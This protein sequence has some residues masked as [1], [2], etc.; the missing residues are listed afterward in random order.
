[1]RP[2]VSTT[3]SP[4]PAPVPPLPLLTLPGLPSPGVRPSAST[5]S[6]PYPAPVPPLP[7]LT[8]PGLPCT[9]CTPEC[10][11]YLLPLPRACSATTSLLTLP[12]LPRQVYARVYQL[13]PPPTP[14]LFRHYL[15]SPSP[16]SPRQVCAR[17]HQLPPPPTPRLFR[18]YL[19]P[20]SPVSPRQVCARVHQLPPP[21]TPRLFR[22][23]LYSP[24]PVSPEPGVRPSAS[25]TSSPYPAPVPPLP[26][27]TLPG[28]PCTRYTPECINYLLPLPR[29]CSA[30]TSLLT[31]PVSL[32]QVCA[33]VYQLPPP[34][35]P[36]LFHHYLSTHPPGLPEP[37]VRPSASTTS[38][39]YP[40]PVPPLPLPTLP[41]LPSPG[42]R[43]SASTTS[44]PYPAPVPPLPLYSPS[45]V[46]LAR[47]APECINYLLPL[48][49]A[50]SATTSL[51]TLPG[52]PSPGVRPSVS[53]TSSPYPAPVP[54]LPLYSPSPVSPRQVCA[55]VYQL[56]P[57]PTPRLFHHYLS[58]HPP[59]LPEPGVRPSASTTSSPYPAP[60]PPLPLPTLPGLPSPGV[61]P[62]ASTT[63]SPYPA[64]VPPLPLYSPSPVS[65]AR[66]APECINYLLPLPRAC[67]ATTSLLT[68][69]GLPSPGVR[70][71]VSTTS[72]P[73]PAPVPPLP[74]YSPSPVSP[75]QVCARVYQLP[76]PPTPRLFHHYLSTHPP[77]LPEPGVRPSASTT[78]SPY[79]APVPPLPLYSPS[80]VSP[81]QVCAGV[82][83]LPPPPT[84]R[85]FR[86][87]L[88]SHPPRS[89][90]PGVR[91]SVSTTS[92]PYPAPVPPLP[93]LT[94]P[95][96]PSPGVRPSASTTSSPY[97]AP[98]P[99]L[100]LYS[101]SPVSPRQVCARVYQ[102]PPPPTPRLFR[103]YL[104]THPPRSHLSQV[105]ARVYQLPPPPTP[106]LFRHYLSTHPPRSP[107]ARC[108]PECI[109]YLLPLPRACSATTSTH[110]PRS[111]SPGVRPS[112]ST[113]SS[114][115]PAPVPPLPL[116][117]L[118]GLPSP[119]VRPSVSTTS[120]PYPAPVPPLPLYSPSPVSPEPGVRPSASTTCASPRRATS[121]RTASRCGR[122]SATGSSRGRRSQ[123]SRSSRPSTNPTSRYVSRHCTRGG[124]GDE[125][126]AQRVGWGAALSV[127]NWLVENR[128]KMYIICFERCVHVKWVVR[129]LAWGSELI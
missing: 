128:D 122:C 100:P 52:L 20:P 41:G 40:A 88:S 23:Y 62:S 67:S 73:Y 43:P 126:Q 93:L 123:D 28:L 74:L 84:P 98:V 70:P 26:L 34:P 81:R 118:P 114:P 9:R 113:T 68:L 127:T 104:S 12:G 58:T 80:P 108:A 31:L 39:P 121:G 120:S 109:N 44:S 46:S 33:R 45:P 56:P 47:C 102:L 63:S 29:A 7:L 105:Y 112:A 17:V 78:S 59:G 51:L 48:P 61:R 72:S 54:P 75:R 42:V 14:R 27:L 2:S 6:S 89:P 19:Y 32:S 99:P 82:H 57:P 96:L 90:S 35:T 106:R 24:S 69:P 115:Y 116:L 101:P 87:Y 30:T 66:C 91:P 77:G 125:G 76:P 103:H 60:V 15:Y 64:P 21:P 37:G 111:P 110:P 55:R 8:L 94:L 1:M 22:H 53:T 3:S 95:G 16:V 38:S 79:P 107:L 83:Q 5:T 85:L 4:Y 129:L 97:P 65:L 25:T 50:C 13:L 18:H 92:S 49:R 119:G 10:I 124:G 11:N 36:R 117:T 71:S 86:H